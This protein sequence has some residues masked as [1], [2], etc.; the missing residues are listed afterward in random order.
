MIRRESLTPKISQERSSPLIS[1]VIPV[2][3][4]EPFVADA[5]KSVLDQDTMDLELVVSVDKSIDQSLKKV[6]EFSDPRMK[7]IVPETELSMAAHYE[8]CINHTRGQWVTILGQ[9]DGLLPNF[10]AVASD[11]IA[12]AGALEAI[13]FR[14][15]Y[16]F[17]PG[18]KD[19][20][21]EQVLIYRSTSKRYKINSRT[22][23]L[24]VL[25]G[26]KEHYD[27]PQLYTNNLI[28]RNL[29]LRIRKNSG[30]KF[31]NE[32]TPDVYSGVAVAASTK[33]F[34]RV[35]TPIFWTGSSSASTGIAL[36]AGKNNKSVSDSEK[37]RASKHLEIATNEGFSFGKWVGMDLWIAAKSSSIYVISAL[38]SIPNLPKNMIKNRLAYIAF[39]TAY[40]NCSIS[41]FPRAKSGIDPKQ[42]YLALEA[43]RRR[44]QMSKLAVVTLVIIEI[45]LRLGNWSFRAISSAILNK[46]GLRII[47]DSDINSISKANDFLRPHVID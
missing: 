33:N 2:K 34:L 27:L 15:A 23:L 41:V 11:S 18:C 37:K 40:L 8:F 42:T 35:G 39:A 28:K 5:I 9:D 3:N 29:I 38:H 14:R 16:F 22:M 43:Q 19:V 1:V 32:V 7:V 44:N 24:T 6:L 30:G 13:S 26:L 36:N 12:V 46:R 45:P 25:F 20:Y 21:G 47:G 4:G 17:W 31:I 10:W